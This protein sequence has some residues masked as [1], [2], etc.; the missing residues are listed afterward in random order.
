MM[1]IELRLPAMIGAPAPEMSPRGRAICA[2]F[3]LGAGRRPLLLG[4]L[5]WRVEFPSLTLITGASGSGK[6]TM[7]RRVVRALHRPPRGLRMQCLSQLP[8]PRHRAVADCFSRPLDET[9]ALLVRAGL[10]EPRAWLRAP[11]ALSEGE[12]FRFRLA[13][14]MASE[15]RI[16]IADEFAAPLDRPTARAVAWQFA[17]FVRKS[18]RAAI[19]AT[20]HEDLAEDLQPDRHVRLGAGGTEAE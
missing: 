19:V 10:G 17:R 9:L 6:S 18:G 5:R 8:L 7:L 3:G 1:E 12:Q 4:P 13:R 11:A 20:S 15:A 2:Q 16:L 14:L